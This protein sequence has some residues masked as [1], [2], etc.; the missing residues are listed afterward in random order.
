MFFPTMLL[1]LCSAVKSNKDY[2]HQIAKNT[3]STGIYRA[4][5]YCEKNRISLHI[6]KKIQ[7]HKK[8]FYVSIGT[9]NYFVIH[10]C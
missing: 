5:Q 6:H 8:I 2:C 3:E 9:F 4:F 7:L 1:Q 10:K